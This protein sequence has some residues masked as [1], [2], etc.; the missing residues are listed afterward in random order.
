MKRKIILIF[1]AVLIIPTVFPLGNHVVLAAESSGFNRATYDIIMRWVNF[2]ILAALLIKYGRGP[3]MNF[4]NG[5][6]EQIKEEI[7]QL[8]AKKKQVVEQI[9]EA[10]I[11]LKQRADRIEQIKQKIIAD[12]TREKERIIN[13]ARRESQHLLESAGHK[14]EHQIRQARETV[15]AEM[16]DQAVALATKRL[17]ELMTQADS[18][19]LVAKFIEATEKF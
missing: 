18:E 7:S 8:E 6:K 11:L 14:M 13:Q 9:E 2:L 5:Q 15:R 19:N 12:G 3:I 4:L 16:I 1:L 17:P 10:R